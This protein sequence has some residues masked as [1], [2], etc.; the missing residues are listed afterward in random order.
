[1]LTVVRDGQCYGGIDPVKHWRAG[2][3]VVWQG[4]YGRGAKDGEVEAEE[5]T[6]Q[7]LDYIE[8]L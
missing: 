8:P 5:S 7:L 6:S 2:G 4:W 3:R 1:M